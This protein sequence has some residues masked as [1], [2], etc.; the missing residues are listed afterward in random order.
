MQSTYDKI[1]YYKLHQKDKN[2]IIKKLREILAKEE[3]IKLALI[4]GSLTCRTSIRDIDICI[5]ST[6]PLT[7]NE[8]LY[9]N[10]QIELELGIPVDL[11]ELTK[12]PHSLKAS[13]LQQG[14][15]AKGQ[16]RL[17]HKLLN[18]TQLEKTRKTLEEIEPRAKRRC[19][20]TDST[21]LIRE[22]RE[23]PT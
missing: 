8:L 19:T 4:F 5:H 15:V 16:K 9:L 13:I 20:K 10:A 6:S 18:Q 14:I 3:R 7:F 1:Q 11:V 12:L 2:R 22:D 23:R 17:I 21:A